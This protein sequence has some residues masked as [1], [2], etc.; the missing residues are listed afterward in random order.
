MRTLSIGRTN[1][2]MSSLSFHNG[3]ESREV[4]PLWRRVVVRTL[5]IGR[6]NVLMSSLSFHNG[7][8]SREMLSLWRRVI[9]ADES[10]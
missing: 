1:V 2:P 7:T 4:L 9:A 10:R 6:T 3:T 5:S 8:E